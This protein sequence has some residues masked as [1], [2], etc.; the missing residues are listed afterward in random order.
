MRAISSMFVAMLAGAALLGGC[1]RLVN[2]IDISS[3]G[4]DCTG[5]CEA[6]YSACARGG[7][8]GSPARAV[9]LPA[10]SGAYSACIRSCPSR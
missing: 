5:K 9:V 3:K 4:Q 2:G 6:T 10:C 8:T 1:A 7:P